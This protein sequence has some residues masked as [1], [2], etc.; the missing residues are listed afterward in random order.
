MLILCFIFRRLNFSDASSDAE[1]RENYSI[2]NEGMGGIPGSPAMSSCS[3]G[4]PPHSPIENYMTPSRSRSPII[5]G[6]G[7]HPVATQ[8]DVDNLRALLQEVNFK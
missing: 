3:D 5:S 4:E 8:S 1:Q 7:G 2:T 6:S